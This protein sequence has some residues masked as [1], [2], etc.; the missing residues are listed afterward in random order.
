M[1]VDDWVASVAGRANGDAQ[2]VR[3]AMARVQALL[4]AASEPET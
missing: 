1:E 2:A 3:L 4:E